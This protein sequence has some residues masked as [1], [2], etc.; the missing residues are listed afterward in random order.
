MMMNLLIGLL[1]AIVVIDCLFLMLLVLVQLP[2]KEAGM[3]TAF[4]GAAT[5]AL[6]GAGSG[7]VLTK[8]TKYA[9]GIFLGLAM[10]LSVLI[11]HQSR[12]PGRSLDEELRKKAAPAASTAPPTINNVLPM[13][14]S[15]TSTPTVPPATDIPLT[16]PQTA[17]EATPPQPEK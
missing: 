7:N 10:V 3:G 17:P 13:T 12:E 4:G 1:T 8:L 2:K 16:I 11:I 15:P 6:F 9:S 5:D 14:A